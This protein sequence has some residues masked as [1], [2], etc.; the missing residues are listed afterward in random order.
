MTNQKYNIL[1]GSMDDK[2]IQLFM[3]AV[4]DSHTERMNFK[5]KS[6]KYSK[7]NPVFDDNYSVFMQNSTYGDEK[8]NN[9]LNNA[10]HNEWIYIISDIILWTENTTLANERLLL[11][12]NLGNTLIKPGEDLWYY[13]H[14]LHVFYDLD[15]KSSSWVTFSELPEQKKDYFDILFSLIKIDDKDTLVTYADSYVKNYKQNLKLRNTYLKYMYTL[16]Q[17]KQ[18]ATEAAETAAEAL[19]KAIAEASG[20]K[21]GKLTTKAMETAEQLRKI[22]EAEQFAKETYQNNYDLNFQT[23]LVEFK[24]VMYITDATGD[25]DFE[26]FYAIPQEN[27]CDDS[28]YMCNNSLR[29]FFLN[30]V[31]KLLCNTSTTHKK[32]LK[33]SIGIYK[34]YSDSLGKPTSLTDVSTTS[35]DFFNEA[36]SSVWKLKEGKFYTNEG[37]ELNKEFFDSLKTKCEDLYLHNN[38]GTDITCADMMEKCLTGKKI[39]ECANLLNNKNFKTDVKEEIKQMYP[40]KLKNLSIG[41]GIPMESVHSNK[42][43][44]DIFILKGIDVWF[45]KLKESVSST[46]FDTIKLNT[47]LIAYIEYL[48]TFINSNPHILNDTLSDNNSSTNRQNI[49]KYKKWGILPFGAKSRR[50]SHSDML[51][52]MVMSEQNRNS[53][54]KKI[55]TIFPSFSGGGLNYNIKESYNSFIEDPLSSYSVGYILELQYKK[56][57]EHL[58]ETNKTLSSGDDKKIEDFI[59]QL[60]TNEENL[61]KSI[62]YLTEY[63]KYISEN[64]DFDKEEIDT[65]KLRMLV[66]KTKNKIIKVSEG[67]EQ[68]INVLLEL[69]RQNA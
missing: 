8:V 28:L 15:P 40:D 18:I 55:H 13:K 10:I 48:I 27:K 19:E 30:I 7:D 63:V 2:R 52:L 16:E 29:M 5:I 67:Q 53:M 3:D 51:Q 65:S 39:K 36:T 62:Y 42:Y 50:L 34:I 69:F 17:R 41:L 1:F 12:K 6:E 66:D 49:G 58:K 35:L 46:E 56:I 4:K 47:N 25:K 44:K 57:K 60:K 21:R 32:S 22:E 38:D 68:S 37:K 11:I 26:S 20:K 9:C 24:N 54:I 64:N 61:V 23:Q 43:K 33:E 59:E 45:L 31:K 14:L